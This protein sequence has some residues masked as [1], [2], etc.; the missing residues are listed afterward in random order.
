MPKLCAVHYEIA[1]DVNHG[2]RNKNKIKLIL[3]CCLI[4]SSARSVFNYS[5]LL[6]IELFNVLFNSDLQNCQCHNLIIW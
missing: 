1:L 3:C 5:N 4:D 6:F 2:R